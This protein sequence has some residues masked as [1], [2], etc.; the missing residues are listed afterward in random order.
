M[1]PGITNFVDVHL[2]PRDAT[3][4]VTVLQAAGSPAVGAE[5]ELDQGTY[6]YDPPLFAVTDS[7]G[8]ALFTSLWAGTYSVMATFAE[9]STRLSARA[10]AS[11]VTNTFAA[12]TLTLGATGTIE[13][14][15]VE[16]DGVT[17]VYGANVSIGNLGF[18]STATNGF[19]EFEGVPIGTYTISGSDPVTGAN[20]V[21]TTT[22]T[23][24]NETNT[25]LLME[26]ALG[27]VSGLV[28]NS[29][30]TGFAAGANVTIYYGDG[31]SPT[32]TVTS[33]PNG[34]FSFPGSPL[35]TFSLS[36]NYKV[37]GG[38]PT[39]FGAA[40]GTLTTISNSVSVNIQLQPLNSLTVEVFGTDGKSPAQNVLVIVDGAQQNTSS[41]GFATFGN[42]KIPG[43]YSVTAYSQQGDD[44]SDGAQ[45]N[46][47][48]TAS[49]TNP[50]VT[51]VLPGVGAVAGTV[52]GSDGSTP[53]D[54]AQVTLKS[55]NPLFV[56]QTVVALTGPQGTFDFTDVPL[57]PYLVTA[58]SVSLAASQSGTLITNRETNQITLQL[59]G[60]GTIL[61]EIVRADGVTPVG[62]ED[63]LIQ[64]NAQSKNAGR[65][66]YFTGPDGKFQF[67]NVPLGTIEVSSA[68]TNFDGIINFTTE[69][70]TNGEVLNLGI[71]PYDE[72]DPMVLQT[73]PTNTAIGVPIATSIEL[74]FSKALATN[75]ISPS[76]IFIEGTNGVVD[77]TVT[78]LPGS[79][80]VLNV[81]RITPTQPLQSL[82]TYSIIVV[83]GNLL[84]AT[85]TVVGSGPLDTSGRPLAGSF[86]SDFTTADQTPPVLLSI[87]P[88][89]N[90][91]QINP[92]A[93]PRLVFNKTLNPT[94][95]VFTVT[96][97]SG[98]VA[99]TPALGINGQVMTLLPT[100]DLTANSTYSMTI[101]NVFDLAGNAAVG[102]PY[103]ANFATLITVGP[104]I[105]SLQIASNTVP[106][107]GSTITV[108]AV[109]ATN[110]PG[111]VVTFTQDLNPIGTVSN[112][113]YE[114]PVTLPS[115]GSTIIRATATDQYGNQGQF[116]ALTIAVQLPQP[117]KITF[118]GVF[119]DGFIE[120]VQ[121]NFW[122][123]SQTTQGLYDVEVTNGLLQLAK[124]PSVASPGGLQNVAL[125]LNL[126]AI[127]GAISNDFSVQV[128]FT[129]AV[130]GKSSYDRI[131]LNLGFQNNSVFQEVYDNSS[132]T[133]VHVW[134]GVANG[135]TS[136]TNTS[137]T[138]RVSRAA[139]T[140]T[141]YFNDAPI[142]S[143]SNTAPVTNINFVLENDAG[144][145]DAIAVEYDNFSLT[146]SSVKTQPVPTGSL[147]V[148][149]IGVVS[150]TGISN[151]TTVVTGAAIGSPAATNAAEILAY[152]YVPP[153]A[154]AYFPVQ[155]FAQA[156]D[157]LGAQSG[158]QVLT[159]LVR[160]ATPPTLEILSPTN[161]SHPTGSSFNLTT[162]A[163]DNSSNVTL[164][165]AVS[166]ALAFA[167]TLPL[168]LTPN[169]PVTNFFAVP[170]TNA[171]T[172][173]GPIIATI[174]A[175]DAASNTTVLAHTFW[176]PNTPGPAIA[177]LLIA[178]NLPPL[179]GSNVPVEAILVSN[180]PGDTVAFTQDGVQVGVATNAPYELLIHLPTNGSTSISA[181]ASDQFGNAGVLEVLSIT[182]ESNLL[183]TIQ[184]TRVSPA[185]GPVPSGSSFSVD[186]AAS[187]NGITFDIMAAVGGAASTANFQANGTTLL[188]TGAV[189][190]T[191]IAGQQ[192]QITAEGDG[193]SWPI[194]RPADTRLD[195]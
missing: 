118:A 111:D 35:G 15:F 176:L 126:A 182:V 88:S 85:G 36:A 52:V 6:P 48:L 27:A 2:I 53:V 94:S 49:E 194:Q 21:T 54:N 155:V 157:N 18:A 100:V 185:T 5:L 87:F 154:T 44:Q 146:G 145:D 64:F 192:A 153:T 168:T 86:E 187:G 138:F 174:T 14:N 107:A 8:M 189:P 172:N 139:S 193:L 79:N 130:I 23:Y 61:G 142:F 55:Q 58:V 191:A 37:P 143:E 39:V 177:S 181:T 72:T 120:G 180:V 161:D 133:N 69:L 144:S 119:S 110:K 175:T 83:S 11:V 121:T 32:R 164:N 122:T 16:A 135:V 99:G 13:G 62:G 150:D 66:V 104:T 28:L 9:S 51:L 103:T 56:G 47:Y 93:V 3:I 123:V 178:S 160:D 43:A 152:G 77:A 163:S 159:L 147:V 10:G 117:P 40:T 131:Q 109:L 29:F 30:D 42:L 190:S 82:A 63:V 125:N 65:A 114:I 1:T 106:V 156:T 127:G 141:G 97:P 167:Q 59:G 140:L 112:A 70:A 132:G 20:A 33:D 105:S 17:P 31:K 136:V 166:G 92:V 188:V 89:N 12:V 22:V 183:P 38:G 75:S 129:N 78:L 101:S 71:I 68:A 24:N 60:S 91:V 171:P 73:T 25:V 195:C 26:G 169:V 115:S 151:L 186:V 134:N 170:L 137:G 74:V 128:A 90:A 149:E 108:V 50:V 76:G 34:A 124:V 84:G 81:V 162:V 158:Q 113:P 57:G 96:G 102:Q 45:T 179:A 19:F 116:V 165:L 67:D 184:F 98:L 7:N 4:Q 148:V 95:F 41:N 80:G 173:G 46:F